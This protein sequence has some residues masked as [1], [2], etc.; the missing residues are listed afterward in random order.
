MDEPNEREMAGRG[1]T[2]AGG[3]M[4]TTYA[5]RFKE[6]KETTTKI[7][8]KDNMRSRIRKASEGTMRT[9]T[10]WALNTSTLKGPDKITATTL[11]RAIVLDPTVCHDTLEFIKEP[12]R[13][14]KTQDVSEAIDIEERE[15][16]ETLS[17]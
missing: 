12:S 10:I 3:N 17:A 9:S 1:G 7:R 5:G 16:M 14:V 13:C 15:W 2:N 8:F 6:A 4:G 11:G